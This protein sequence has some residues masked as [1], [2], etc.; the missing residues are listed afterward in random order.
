M[1]AALSAKSGKKKKKKKVR[2]MHAILPRGN[3]S[4]LYIHISCYVFKI[5]KKSS[6]IAACKLQR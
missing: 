4:R 2:F 6:F 5:T 1:K 3:L